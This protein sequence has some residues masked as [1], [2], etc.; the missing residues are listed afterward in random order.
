MENEH[1]CIHTDELNKIYQWLFEGNGTK[2][3]TV[4]IENLEIAVNK[5]A[6]NEKALQYFNKALVDKDDIVCPNSDGLIRFSVE[7]PAEIIG[8]CNSNPENIT[9]FQ[10]PEKNLFHGRA[11]VVLK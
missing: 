3:A 7:G 5:F 4:R 8:V 11:L 10:K 1:I 2:P 6:E 9:S